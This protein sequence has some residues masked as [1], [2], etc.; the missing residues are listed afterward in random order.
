MLKKATEVERL[1]RLSLLYCNEVNHIGSLC[2]I[3]APVQYYMR[4]LA[5]T[6]VQV[7][8]MAGFSNEQTF[9][10]RHYYI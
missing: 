2:V 7:V 1:Y 10:V 3:K 8:K 6:P 4:H 5:L 9:F